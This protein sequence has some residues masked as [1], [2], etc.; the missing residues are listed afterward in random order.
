MVV[1][2]ELRLAFQTY[3]NAMPHLILLT[4]IDQVLIRL[5]L[6]QFDIQLIRVLL[7]VRVVIHA[8]EKIINP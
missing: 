8:K 6:L 7:V 2:L 4:Y 3:R 1:L 5:F